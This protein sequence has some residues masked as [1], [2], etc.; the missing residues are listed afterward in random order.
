MF[1][2]AYCI[3]LVLSSVIVGVMFLCR[4][5]AGAALSL[6]QLDRSR[7]GAARR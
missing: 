2:I 4:L 1:W 6:L 5:A 3:T 7:V